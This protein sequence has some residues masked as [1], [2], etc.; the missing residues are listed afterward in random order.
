MNGFK[1]AGLC[2]FNPAK[3][4]T[5]DKLLPSLQFSDKRQLENQ[6][7]HAHTSTLTGLENVLGNEKVKKLEERFEEG[8]DS[9]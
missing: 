5:N 9:F 2:P 7:T 6:P 1:E 4:L 3:V 8:Y